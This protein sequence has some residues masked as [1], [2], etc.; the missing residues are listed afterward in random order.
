V[1]Y[2]E[3][4]DARIADLVAG[5]DTTRKPMF[6]GA[7]Y[8]LRGNMLAGAWKEFLILRLGEDA[9]DRA[10]GQPNVRVFDITGRPMKGWVMVEPAGFEG[11][12][13]ATW[14]ELAKSYV[15]RLPPK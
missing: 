3:E 4:L 11:E 2:D 14:L 9:G 12:A 6:G 5:W 7:C 8:L 1:A 13:L 15:E 10:L